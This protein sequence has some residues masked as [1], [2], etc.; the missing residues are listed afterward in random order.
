MKHKLTR[1]HFIS[2]LAGT[3]T[4]LLLG[5]KVSAKPFDFRKTSDDT[6]SEPFHKHFPSQDPQ[7]VLEMVI[8][9]HRF[10]VNDERR[11][12]VDVQ[13]GGR[14]QSSL[15]AV[16]QTIADDAARRAAGGLVV[17]AD[18]VVQKRLDLGGTIQAL[19]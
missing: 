1:K 2:T 9:S 3:S 11:N 8:V 4:M 17:V 6:N 18:F 5:Q 14:E 19:Q 16:S 10:Q 13:C 12:S 15:G 7:L